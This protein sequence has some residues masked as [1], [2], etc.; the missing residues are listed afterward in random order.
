MNKIN[1]KN[2]QL[3]LFCVLVTFFFIIPSIN[4]QVILKNEVK[5]I[6]TIEKTQ[7]N[8]TLSGYVKDPLSNPID[9]AVIIVY[10]HETYEIGYSDESGHYTVTNIPI[11]YCMK[12]CTCS[13]EG[14]KTEWVLLAITEN[15][16]QDFILNP[17]EPYALFNGTQ[18]NGWWNS[19]V[20]VTFIYD[21]DEVAEIWY[22]YQGLHLYT[23]PF[24][25]DDEGDITVDFYWFDYEGVQ[26]P[27]QCFFIQIDQTPPTIAIQWETY[28]KLEKWYVKF[29]LDASDDI[30][31]M[32]SYLSIFIN[33]V[34]QAE[35]EVLNWHNV[36]FECQLSNLYKSFGFGC[37]DNACNFVI[38][39]VNASDIKTYTNYAQKS[40]YL[41]LNH[42]FRHF[43]NL[44]SIF[45]KNISENVANF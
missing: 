18:C 6:N 31:G 9:D 28:K 12:N 2:F 27:I 20:T 24:V 13:K 21:P 22:N 37:S 32:D 5:N 44:I 15:T 25:I 26:S 11:C 4:G 45:K 33:E 34:L 3:K 19:S 38:K 10:F 23:G 42:I 16:T 1:I 36:W 29:L 41:L 30:S 39:N 43:S 7:N 8:G 40:F 14:Y 35:F 17:N